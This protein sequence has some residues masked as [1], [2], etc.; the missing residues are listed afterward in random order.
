MFSSPSIGT[1][2]TTTVDIDATMYTVYI[3]VSFI[4]EWKLF[5]GS[6]VTIKFGLNDLRNC[7]I[8]LV[9]TD[10]SIIKMFNK[11]FL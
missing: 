1:K 6:V 5:D 10:I 9:I 11:Q 2:G 7:L 3:Y 4:Y 8:H